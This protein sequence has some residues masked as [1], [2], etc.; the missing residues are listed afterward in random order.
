MRVMSA[1]FQKAAVGGND[2]EGGV[3]P[4]G[5]IVQQAD[6]KAL[7]GVQ[8]GVPGRDA[9]RK[10]HSQISEPDGHA[11]ADAGEKHPAPLGA[12]CCIHMQKILFSAR[13][14]VR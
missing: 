12:L 7:K 10:R 6:E 1:I 2:G 5:G 4:G 3:F 14:A 8:P 13:H 9:E 11:V